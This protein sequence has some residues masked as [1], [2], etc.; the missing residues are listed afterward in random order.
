MTTN[1]VALDRFGILASKF[2]VMAFLVYCHLAMTQA[3]AADC[4]PPTVSAYTGPLFDAM[5]QSG[6]GLDGEEAIRTAKSVGVTRMALF[7]RVHIKEDGRSLVNHL[8]SAHPDFITLGTQKLF[9]MRGDLDSLYVNEV[10]DDIATKRYR[11]VGEILFTHGD[12]VNGEIT[13]TGER[14]IDP[15]GPQTERLVQG[16]KGLHVPIMT[17]WEVYDWNRDWPKFNRLYAAHPDQIFIWPHLGFAS[18]QQAETVLA[19]NQN[20]W[21]TLSKREPAKHNLREESKEELVGGP[22]TDQ[23]GNLLPEWREVMVRFSDRLMFATD[24]HME[25][26]WRHYARVVARWRVIL[27]QL[28]PNVASAIAY[29]NAPDSMALLRH[30]KPPPRPNNIEGKRGPL[31]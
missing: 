1:L 14:Y 31:S 7:A 13:A 5:A 30:I 20:V 17:H 6:Q 24:A 28:P 12:K 4:E 26:R 25:N 19:A 23:C 3:F 10:L 11:F 8:A 9:D 21:A 15:N 27:A 18:A 29:D 22:V 16:L 2:M